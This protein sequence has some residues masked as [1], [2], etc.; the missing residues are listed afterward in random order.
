MS[1]DNDA[2]RSSDIRGFLYILHLLIMLNR[3]PVRILTTIATVWQQTITF[4]FYGFSPFYCDPGSISFCPALTFNR[5]Y[6]V[7]RGIQATAFLNF[8]CS[9]EIGDYGA[10]LHE[11]VNPSLHGGSTFASGCECKYQYSISEGSA[12][13]MSTAS[14]ISSLSQALLRVWRRPSDSTWTYRLISWQ[15]YRICL[16]YSSRIA[17]FSTVYLQPRVSHQ[18]LNTYSSMSWHA[19]RKIFIRLDLN[20]PSLCRHVSKDPRHR[21]LPY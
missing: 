19:E 10:S 2:N 16:L 17:I 18:R 1:R 21:R 13:F 14:L 4:S 5:S 20:T 15:T 7:Q 9:D 11:A 12:E 3:I 8:G 6:S